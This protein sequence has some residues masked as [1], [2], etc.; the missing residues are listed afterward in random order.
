MWGGGDEG[1]TNGK[2]CDER[3]NERRAH[4][5]NDGRP[6]SK[7]A[8][9]GAGV[10]TAT[11]ALGI[12]TERVFYVSQMFRWWGGGVA[13]HKVASE[14]ESSVGSTRQKTTIKNEYQEGFINVTKEL[15]TPPK[16][17]V[18]R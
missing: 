2:H 10:E 3:T 17:A 18:Q 6:A 11:A 8:G 15:S 9:A 7:R 13:R 16:R 4:A 14:S 5:R 12:E 1:M